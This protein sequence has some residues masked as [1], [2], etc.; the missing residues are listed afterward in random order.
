MPRHERPS[1]KSWEDLVAWINPMVTISCCYS[2]KKDKSS[3]ARSFQ[4]SFCIRHKKAPAA[5]GIW[6]IESRSATV[7][8]G[9]K[10][11]RDLISSN[12]RA[13]NPRKDPRPP[14]PFVCR[15]QPP[16]GQNN[17]S[18]SRARLS[19]LLESRLGLWQSIAVDRKPY[20]ES[21]QQKDT[22]KQSADK[23]SDNHYRKG[24]L[25]I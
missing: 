18:A 9:G 1:T 19:V 16:C 6:Q 13:C 12:A 3:D 15:T 7:R 17:P 25:R 24:P 10:P 5:E 11:R 22:Q 8:R 14:V 4:R 20:I 2:W 21:R 23:P